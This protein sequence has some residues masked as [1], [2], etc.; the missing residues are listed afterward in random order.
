[1][2]YIVLMYSPQSND[3]LSED[4]AIWHILER[5]KYD[6]ATFGGWLDYENSKLHCA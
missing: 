5:E 1:M 6:S 2:A 3:S 4:F